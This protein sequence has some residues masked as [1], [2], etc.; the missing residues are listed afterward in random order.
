MDLPE[1]PA[2]ERLAAFLKAHAQ[3]ES[4]PAVLFA[5]GEDLYRSLQHAP[6]AIPDWGRFLVALGQLASDAD[7]LGVASTYFLRAVRE[8]ELHTDYEAMITAGY[9]QGVLF[10]RRERAPQARAAYRVAAV[11]GF[12]LA[13]VH[14]NTVRSAMALIRMHFAE[15]GSLDDLTRTLAKQ[16]WLGWLHLRQAQPQSL[17]AALV[18]ELERTFC[19]LLLPEDP[20]ELAACWRSW[21]PSRLRCG[22][23]IVADDADWVAL[24]TVAAEAAEHQLQDEGPDPGGP[25]R[26]LAQAARRLV[27]GS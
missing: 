15:Y 4:V 7:D 3:V 11:E 6:P 27:V 14:A 1:A 13:A 9:D 5:R 24:F 23:S 25:Y 17:D 16:A 2:A 26:L 20:A 12:R 10:E 21:P 18:G 19:A 22:E 8:A